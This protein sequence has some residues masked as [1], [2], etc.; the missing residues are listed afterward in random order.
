M[1]EGP[2][3]PWGSPSMHVTDTQHG[4][5]SDLDTARTIW[6]LLHQMFQDNVISM[7]ET[8]RPSHICLKERVFVLGETSISEI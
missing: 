5:L 4:T 2:L 7:S 8:F 6:Q 1:E 3:G